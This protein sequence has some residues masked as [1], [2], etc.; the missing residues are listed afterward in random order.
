MISRA[1]PTLTRLGFYGPATRRA[2]YLGGGRK[3]ETS[4]T[5]KEGRWWKRTV[6]GKLSSVHELHPNE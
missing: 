1:P 3:V 6:P 5:R 4:E 2:S